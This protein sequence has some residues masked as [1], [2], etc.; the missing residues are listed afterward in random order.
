MGRRVV[1]LHVLLNELM[2]SMINKVLS[3]QEDSRKGDFWWLVPNH[4][5]ALNIQISCLEMAL[6]TGS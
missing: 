6:E 4:L 1:F 5:E 2:D 3:R